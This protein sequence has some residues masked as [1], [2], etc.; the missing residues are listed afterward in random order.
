MEHTIKVGMH[1]GQLGCN[2]DALHV[3]E[4]DMVTWTT[5]RETDPVL[6]QWAVVF[7]PESPFSEKVVTSGTPTTK[8]T[9][10][11]R[12]DPHRHK[13]VVLA[14]D[15]EEIKVGDPDLIVDE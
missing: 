3:R 10:H 5:D 4:H 1:N 6:E 13:Y 7:G 14:F 8:V 11:R 15:G 12:C 2:P 9:A